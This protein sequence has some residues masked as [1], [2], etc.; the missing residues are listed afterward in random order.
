[1][2]LPEQ[3]RRQAEEVDQ[4]Y[5][6]QEAAEAQPTSEEASDTAAP[7]QVAE[8]VSITQA[9]PQPVQQ[10][11]HDENDATW[12]QRYRS[13]Q[14][15]FNSQDVKYREAVAQIDQL[16][17]AL[18]SLQA[19]PAAQRDSAPTSDGAG[20]TPSEEQE[21]TPEFF[22]MMDRWLSARISPLASQV[23]AVAQHVP[24]MQ[25]LTAQ[26]G[27]VAAVQH[28][29]VEQQFFDKL[30]ARMPA[31]DQINQTPAFI[32]WLAQVDPLTGVSRQVYLDDARA[33]L[34]LD[35]VVNIFSAFHGGSA[36][37]GQDSSKSNV[38]DLSQQAVVTSRKAGNTPNSAGN[39]K[40]Y[41]KSDLDKLY[42]DY[43][44][45]AYK[46]KDAEFKSKEV[47]LLAAINSGRYHR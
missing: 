12:A 18:M 22:S 43:R 3:V 24:S 14:G 26:V 38:S 39:E 9:A 7:A 45:G 47:E 25:S 27:H 33:R 15:M 6:E 4:Y 35:R 5:S 23:Q 28:R 13:L 30:S 44:R 37:T 17:S 31:W 10:Q 32:Q 16:R 21:Y 19:Q 41:S 1:M 20:I 46:G 34:D 40:V 8:V 2:G 29:S 36:G 42:A 11:N